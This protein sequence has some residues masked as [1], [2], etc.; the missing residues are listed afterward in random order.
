MKEMDNVDPIGHGRPREPC[1]A[2]AC[3]CGLPTNDR[4]RILRIIGHSSGNTVVAVVTVL[5]GASA[6][7]SRCIGTYT[8]FELDSRSEPWSDSAGQNPFF[9]V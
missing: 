8:Q 5:C 7:W 2:C 6:A 4:C 9:T 3:A 1:R